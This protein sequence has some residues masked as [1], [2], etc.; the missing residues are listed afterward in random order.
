VRRLVLLGGG[1][2]HVQ[3]LFSLHDFVSKNL[4]VTLVSAGA[5]HTY[6]GMVP[7]V[8]AG[9][10]SEDQAQIDLAALCR[11]SATRLYA[12]AATGIDP[13]RKCVTL[14]DGRELPYDLL[15][16]NVGASPNWSKVPGAAQHAVGVKPFDPFIAAWRRLPRGSNVAVVG[17]GAAGVELAMAMTHA[18]AGAVTLFS[19]KNEFRP[20]VASR[21][22]RA[23]ARMAVVVKAKTPVTEVAAGPELLHEGGKQKFDAVFW[24]AGA[25]A[26]PW[27]A[28]S[29][30][31]C[32]DGGYVRID[33]RLRSIS[34]PDVFAAGDAAALEGH[35]LPKSGV[36]AVRQG[37]VLAENLKRAAVG[38]EPRRYVPQKKTLYLISCGER[39]AI[40]SRGGWSAEGAWAWRW[41]DWIDRRWMARFR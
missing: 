41:K 31:A 4:E 17:G 26:L 30:L 14:T 15:S 40:A 3:V 23:L 25:S 20:E 33:D 34:H 39:Y 9:H 27:L 38:S 2:A 21:L 19:E 28:E 1:H 18:G 36:Y 16:I 29:G 22:A 24:A 37:A 12:S 6:S 7:G 35:E 32:N 8:I 10:Y 13:R 11:K 5:R